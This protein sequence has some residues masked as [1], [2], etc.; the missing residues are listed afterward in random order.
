LRQPARV[1]AHGQIDLGPDEWAAAAGKETPRSTLREDCDR[2]SGFAIRHV[3]VD[4]VRNGTR[5]ASCSAMSGFLTFP[6]FPD[7]TRR[8]G[9]RILEDAQH[10]SRVVP[11]RAIEISV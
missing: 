10:E 11:D 5:R 8:K 9:R 3:Y 6:S 1:I 4:A 2:V 7:R